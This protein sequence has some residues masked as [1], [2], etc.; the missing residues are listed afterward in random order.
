[1]DIKYSKEKNT[2]V[3][4]MYGDIDHHTSSEIKDKIDREFIRN[5]FKNILFDFSNVYFMDSSGIGMIIGRYKNV[6]AK[7]GN[8]MAIGIGKEIKRLFEISGLFKI[9]R[10]YSDIKTALNEAI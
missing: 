10:T 6:K 9:I 1:M 7:G 3:V 5:N 8:V 2:L 4:K